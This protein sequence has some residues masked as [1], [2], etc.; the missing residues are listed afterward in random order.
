M[1]GKLRWGIISTAN[2]GLKAVIPA[3]QASQR[4][5]VVAIASRD[6][7]TAKEAAAGLGIPKAYGSYEAL[8]EAPDI[9]AV[10]NPLPNHLHAEWSIAAAKAGKHVLCEKPL[11]LS[12][13]EASEMVAAFDEAGVKLMEAF[14]YRLHP[15][16]AMVRRLVADGRIGEL[17]AVNS[18][19]SYNN[20]DPANIR[21][22]VD[23][24]GGGLMDIG[25]YCVNVSRMLFGAEPDE[26][27]AL[28]QRH[29]EFG[30]D[31]VTAA[32]MRFGSGLASFTCSTVIEDFQR[33]EIVGTAGRIEVEV[34]FNAWP[35]RPNRIVVVNEGDGRTDVGVDHVESEVADQ[36]S[37]QA[38]AFAAAVLDNSPLP[39]AASDSVANMEVIDRIFAA[40]G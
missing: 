12:A 6:I 40:A 13:G 3:T 32:V 37:L 1:T 36:Y 11:A 9:D 35:D 15:Q 31:V 38:D 18:W 21:N 26:V 29:P 14:M 22:V 20:T 16:W 8:L 33:V 25:C 7:E 39:L 5:E 24:G 10:Y 28:M 2:I 19:F 30:T 23:W 17:K 4:G 27:K 34:P